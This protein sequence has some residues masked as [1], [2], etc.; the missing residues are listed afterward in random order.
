MCPC[1]ICSERYFFLRC[2]PWAGWLSLAVFPRMSA[3]LRI[4][5]LVLLSAV[6]LLAQT[7]EEGDMNID[8]LFAKSGQLMEAKQWTEALAVMDTIM[9][10]YGEQGFDDFGPVFG[11]MHYRRGYCLKNL[12]RFDEAVAAYEVCYNKGSNPPN[13][14]AGMKNPVWELAM[15][16]IGIVRQA[17]GKFKEAVK[18]YE[19]FASKPPPAGSYDEASFRVVVA[20]AYEKAGQP[21]RAK[22]LFD[23]I[24]S[25]T[26]KATPE[27]AFRGFLA[28]MEGWINEALPGEELAKRAHASLSANAGKMALSPYEMLKHDFTGKVVFLAN[29]ALEMKQ[30]TLA[31]RL[32]RLI[33][34]VEDGLEDLRGR[35]FSAVGG[36]PADLSAELT[37]WE[38]EAK[39]DDHA[40]VAPML[41]MASAYDLL[42]D[43]AMALAIVQEAEQ[44]HPKSAQRSLVLFGGMRYA[45]GT[46]NNALSEQ[47]GQKFKA[48]FPTHSLAGNVH[49]VMLE[50]L[51]FTQRYDEALKLAVE[52]QGKESKEKELADFI[53][54]A[55][56]YNLGQDAQAVVD[57]GHYL[58][59]YPQGKYAEPCLYFE[60]STLVRMRQYEAAVPK[61]TAFENGHDSSQYFPYALLDHASCLFQLRQYAACIEVVLRMEKRAAGFDLL[62]K[63]IGMAADCHLMQSQYAEAQKRYEQAL[64]T[65]KGD[66]AGRILV[67]LTR[68]AL[69]LGKTEEALKHYDMYAKSHMGGAH[70]AEAIVSAMEPLKSVG[71]GKEALDALEKVVVSLGSKPN[72]VGAEEALGSYVDLYAAVEG[73]VKLL[74]R[75]ENFSSG[76]A[77]KF[78]PSFQAWLLMARINVLQKEE[79]Q[80]QFP[81]AAAQSIVAFQELE[82]FP[83]TELSPAILTHMG[84][85]YAAKND[86]SSHVLAGEFFE[87]VLERGPSDQYA[88][89]LSGQA[90][91]LARSGTAAD[92]VKA[93][94]SLERVITELRDQPAY[95]EEAMLEKGRILFAQEKWKESAE[96]FFAMQG[97]KRFTQ[98]RGEV[99]YRLGLS[100]EALGMMDK[101]LEAYTPFV[102]P[103]LESMVQ[104]SAEARYRAASIQVKQGNKEKAYRLARDTISR[105]YK[106]ANDPKGGGFIEKSRGLYKQLRDELKMEPHKDELLWGVR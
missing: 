62:G 35:A 52:L 86:P 49:T 84:R 77:Q 22:M 14:D 43:A 25:G 10:E 2:F 37:R 48:E 29:K 28:Q 61:L 33:P 82:K 36:P 102:A 27:A 41:L 93:L 70:D 53:V 65:A 17:Q 96:T 105:M 89:A 81:K 101:A 83:R 104:Y 91:L 44:K 94:Q 30:A 59:T 79:W 39:K 5:S 72:A 8:G 75:L 6:L 40:D 98:T 26:I 54:A 55:C 66:D 9:K 67:Q 21:E 23:Q 92:K 34:S 47:W 24:F 71:R 32:L 100:Y 16:E 7:A 38:A 45:L 87:A 50:N 76:A 31:I 56:R 63:A 88:V 4:T 57:L 99:F 73:P 90:R 11:V 68:V 19:T 51:F 13:V 64:V 42:G 74:E 1:L 18:A 3:L 69:A 60:A 103:P 85:S 46:K 95:V 20:Q 58:K 97:D 80:A 106:L 12:Q 15:L 78:P